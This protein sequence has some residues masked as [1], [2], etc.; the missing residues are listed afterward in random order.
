LFQAAAP[1]SQHTSGVVLPSH[2]SVAVHGDA[3]YA[4]VTACDQCQWVTSPAYSVYGPPDLATSSGTA[5]LP[6]SQPPHIVAHT[7]D[8]RNASELYAWE[9]HQMSIEVPTLL[10]PESTGFALVNTSE[11]SVSS[12][13]THGSVSANVR[14]RKHPE[15]P[16]AFTCPLDGCTA[17]F[18][19]ESNVKSA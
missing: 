12:V 18:T 17:T 2:E 8:T 10:P 14:R 5:A 7:L 13:R 6:Y 1:F 3:T 16:P 4:Q 15:A 19:R 9:R 11:G